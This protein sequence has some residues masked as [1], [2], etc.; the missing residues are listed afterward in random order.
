MAEFSSMGKK[1]VSATNPLSDHGLGENLHNHHSESDTEKSGD[2]RSRKPSSESGSGAVSAGKFAQLKGKFFQRVSSLKPPMSSLRLRPSSRTQQNGGDSD[3][4][5]Q[6]QPL[7]KFLSVR[8]GQT[9][10]SSD[11]FGIPRGR[12]PP[13][14][15]PSEEELRRETAM[16]KSRTKFLI[17]KAV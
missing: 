11:V 4:S 7:S 8:R 14:N 16:K 5:V 17:L 9:N 12:T 3:S 10:S 1:R 6:S 13:R 2:E 15:E